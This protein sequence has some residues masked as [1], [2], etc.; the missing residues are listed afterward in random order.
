MPKLLYMAITGFKDDDSLSSTS[1]GKE[2]A[3]LFRHTYER[4]RLNVPSSEI[5]AR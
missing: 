1:A 2:N 3:Q 5:A 4:R